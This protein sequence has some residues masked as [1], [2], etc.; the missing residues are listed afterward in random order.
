MLL[1][2]NDIVIKMSAY[3]LDQE[4]LETTTL[5]DNPPA[6]LNVG[7]YV[8]RDRLAKS[9]W[10][11]NV[12]AAQ[13]AFERFL[14]VALPLDP[15]EAELIVAADLENA[16]TRNNLELDG[17]ESQLLAMAFVRQNCFLLTGDKRAIFA[18]AFIAAD[19]AQYKLICLEQLL[20]ELIQQY[21]FGDIAQKVCSEPAADTALN[22][23]FGCSST[24]QTTYDNVVEALLSYINHLR[25]RSANTLLN[26]TDLS[27]LSS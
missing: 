15:T 26:S 11:I 14:S 13:A 1:V 8:I 21:C 25:A 20:M 16:A 6:M 19:E 9:S 22:L 5:D 3:G 24:N 12:S 10:L 27:A 18:I 23:C 7:K 2:D 17:G 4:F